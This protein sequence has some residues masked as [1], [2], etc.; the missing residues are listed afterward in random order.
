M[1][2][3]QIVEKVVILLVE[4]WKKFSHR[5]PEKAVRVCLSGQ[6]FVH[7]MEKLNYDERAQKYK[8]SSHQIVSIINYI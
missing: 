4:R 5:R 2:F 8:A 3:A 6:S 1:L 7:L